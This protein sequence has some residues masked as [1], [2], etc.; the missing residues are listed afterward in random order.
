M[1]PKQLL[2][3]TGPVAVLFLSISPLLGAQSAEQPLFSND[4][5]LDVSIEAPLTSLMKIRPDD[6]YLEGTFSY[7]D[8]SG[9]PHTFDLK[10][11]TRGKFRRQKSTCL[12]A[13]IRLN[14]KTSQLDDSDFAGQDKLKLVTHCHTGRE[15]YEQL[16]LRE[17]LTYRILQVLTDHSFGARLMRITYINSEEDE[18]FT[19]YGFVIEDEDDIG[20]RLGLERLVSSGL[21]YSELDAAHTNMVIMFQY[22]IGNT[23]FSLIRGPIENECCHNAIPFSNGEIARSIPYD[24]DHS[25][26]VDAPYA[27]PNPQFKTRSVRTRVYRGLCGYNE[28]LPD[29]L[30]YMISKKDEIMRLVDD[31]SALDDRNRK[32]VT[33]YLNEFFADISDPKSVENKLIKKCS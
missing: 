26:L 10:L 18:R 25:G 8:E 3:L 27:K 4:S 16:V 13:P 22:M 32:E 21:K 14:F 1:Y 15:S 23:D 28:F 11:R 29:S 30:A 7:T 17:Y 9:L 31:L 6:E 12:F 5:V 33:S 24:F 19:R 2:C 20:K